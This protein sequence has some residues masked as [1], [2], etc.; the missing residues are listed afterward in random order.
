MK[1]AHDPILFISGAGLPAWIWEETREELGA[2]R[3]TVVA[4]RPRPGGTARLRD[5]TEAAV[6]SAPAGS[7][8][9]V[10]HSS[11]GVVGAEV[12]RLV[13]ERVSAFLAVTAVVPPPGGSFI[14]AMP[15]PNRW[16]LSLAMRIAGTRPPAAAIR[17]GIAGGLDARTADRVVAD[18]VPESPGLYRDDTSVA[19]LTAPRGYVITTRDR[20]LP[21]RLQRTFARRLDAP[22]QDELTAGHL[23]MI[24]DPRALAG[25]I[26]RF[27]TQR[28][29]G[30]TTEETRR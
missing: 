9:I 15:I 21:P 16:V 29:T 10:A 3:H 19:T 26:T 28:S 6:A 20:E 1:I 30:V 4:A 14:S 12:A 11:G 13:P 7:F 25:S 18:F 2:A 27:L 24:E 8:A 17:R 5:Y 22:W 23:P